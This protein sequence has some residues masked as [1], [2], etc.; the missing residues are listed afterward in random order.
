MSGSK[1]VPPL[2]PEVAGRICELASLPPG[3]NEA[4]ALLEELASFH[5]FARIDIREPS[6]PE[7]AAE[8]AAARCDLRDAVVALEAAW[9]L[10]NSARLRLVALGGPVPPNAWH[11]ELGLS[12]PKPDPW[13]GQRMLRP[14]DLKATDQ[15]AGT[16]LRQLVA[17]VSTDGVGDSKKRG[18]RPTNTRF[19]AA[20]LYDFGVAW[21]THVGPVPTDEYWPRL[22]DAATLVLGFGKSK[23]E[24]LFRQF[25][26][27]GWVHEGPP[28]SVFRG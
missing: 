23:L 9:Q 24:K 26:R 2:E 19:D 3:S 4:K 16:F 13:E 20:L 22:V 27:E 12:E 14:A 18:G 8:I 6:A 7:R 1:E 28:S 10:F 5:H 21:H 11:L 15:L 25:R 17:E